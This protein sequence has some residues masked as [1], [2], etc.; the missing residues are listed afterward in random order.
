LEQLIC[1]I[2]SRL[3]PLAKAIRMGTFD[4]QDVRTWPMVLLKLDEGRRYGRHFEKRL[5]AR[6]LTMVA[7]FLGA[8]SPLAKPELRKGLG[9]RTL[10]RLE[11]KLKPY[12][13]LDELAWKLPVQRDSRRALQDEIEQQIRELNWKADE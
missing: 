3:N 1:E 4:A 5:L 10:D 12:G 9:R 2:F 13:L 11:E 8:D 7:H 6:H